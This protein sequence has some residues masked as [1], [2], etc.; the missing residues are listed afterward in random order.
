[1]PFG[2]LS[3]RIGRRR[4]IIAGWV[5]YAIAYVGFAHATRE[6]HIWLLFVFYG[7]TEGVEKAFIADIANPEERG[8]AFGW[9]NF[10]IGAGALPA[11]LIFGFVWQKAGANIAFDL[12]ALIAVVAAVL[13]VSLIRPG[14]PEKA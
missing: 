4:V 10:A 3:D 12:G 5:V 2:A 11:S 9:Y 13:L 7:L 1:M 14:V 6:I 8:G